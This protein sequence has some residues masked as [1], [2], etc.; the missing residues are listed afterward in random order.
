MRIGLIG[1]GIVGKAAEKT[2]MNKY[3]VIKYD[4]YLESDTFEELLICDF[5]FIMVPT[6]FDCIE[7]KTDDSAI[8]ESLLKLNKA[9]YMNPVIIK[10]T[11]PPGSC[12]SYAANYKLEIIF[13]P[14]FLRESTTPDED[15]ASQ[16]TVVIGTD[17]SVTFHTVKK[18]YESVL[19]PN[20]KYFQTSLIE[21]EM[22]KCAQNTMLASRVAL[23]NM[24]FDACRKYGI[25]YN[26]I[27]EIAFDRFDVLGPHMVKVP[28]PDGKRGFGGKCL[29]KDIRSFSTFYESALLKEI[30]DYNDNLRDD[31]DIF[32]TNYKNK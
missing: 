32:L 20:A 15:F 25:D 9:R 31:L 28:G 2:F 29:P 26:I 6:P 30:I 3:K 23:A 13:N 18:M 12:D 22:T 11:V 19:V 8:V 10:S 1:Y 14:E 16:N 4:K 7:N 24:I 17:N 21:A 27:R 5:I